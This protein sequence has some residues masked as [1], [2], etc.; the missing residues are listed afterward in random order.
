MGLRQAT[1]PWDAC[2]AQLLWSRHMGHRLE[3]E[4]GGTRLGALGHGPRNL[5]PKNLD[6]RLRSDP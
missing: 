3:R 5:E 1:R 6:L 4:N 2:V